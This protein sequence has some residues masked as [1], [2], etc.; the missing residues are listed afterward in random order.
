MADISLKLRAEALGKSLE[1]IAPL[2]EEELNQAVKDLANAAYTA[3]VSQVQSMNL[4]PKNRAEY[5]KGLKF[6]KLGNDS[7]LITLDSEWANKL[8]NG[9]GGYS[10]RDAML[11]STKTVQVGSRAGEPWV[12]KA[13]D[14]HKYAA[15]PMQ[16]RPYGGGTAGDLGE[17]IKKLYALGTNNKVQKITKIFKDVDGNPIRGKVAT[18][19]GNEG[20]NPQLQGLTKFQSVSQS[21]KVSSIYMTFRMVSETGKDWVSPGKKGYHLFKKAQDFVEKE[22]DNIIMK[23]LK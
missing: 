21:G 18:V 12:R 9:F 1:K 2:V 7:F 22:M 15:V 23:V 11:K 8:E 13:K 16:K 4:D 19:Q 3:M 20:V 14:G 5:L 10:I 6:S 17:E